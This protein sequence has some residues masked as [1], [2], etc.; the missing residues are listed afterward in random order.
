MPM[1]LS[2]FWTLMKDEFGE[3][4]AASVA[5][6]HVLGSLGNRTANTALEDGIPP[7]DVWFALCDDMGVPESRR[8]GKEPRRK[9]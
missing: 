6:D 4:Y 8:L 3:G 2:R 1:R 7:R 9:R 5:A